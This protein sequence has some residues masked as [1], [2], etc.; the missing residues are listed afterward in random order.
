M[1]KRKGEDLEVAD[2]NVKVEV[3]KSLKRLVADKTFCTILSFEKIENVIEKWTVMVTIFREFREVP[4]SLLLYYSV[5][6]WPTSSSRE[7][8]LKERGK[9]YAHSMLF[10]I[11]VL[12]MTHFSDKLYDG[13]IIIKLV[14][15]VH[16]WILIVV[17]DHPSK[18]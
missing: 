4:R 8:Y 13:A 17:R 14:R 10:F 16:V 2:H 12:T 1:H 6:L 15:N 5:L 9:F 11:V 18:L 3:M 7:N